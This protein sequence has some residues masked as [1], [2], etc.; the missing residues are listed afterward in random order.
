[1]TD[2]D[3]DGC[4]IQILLLTFFFRFMQSLI[5][6]GMVYIAL[7]PLYKIANKNQIEYAW[8][9]DELKEKTMRIK[10]YTIQRF[11]GLGEMNPDQLWETT[12]NPETRILVRVNIE[13]FSEAD[14]R[15]SVLMG[16]DVT[17]RREWID[18]NVVFENDDNFT[19]EEV[20]VDGEE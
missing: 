19:L 12:M 15:V 13:D 18:N 16:D 8:D 10:N 7:T 11:K 5:K 14:E 4:H 6:R 17:P 2:A 9:D 20:D 1:M 3:D